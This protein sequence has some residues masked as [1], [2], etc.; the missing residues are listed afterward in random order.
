MRTHIGSILE[1][2]VHILLGAIKDYLLSHVHLLTHLLF[3]VSVFTFT[4]EL[5]RLSTILFVTLLYGLAPEAIN[6]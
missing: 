6:Q 5:L 1:R 3:G 2:C 4:L